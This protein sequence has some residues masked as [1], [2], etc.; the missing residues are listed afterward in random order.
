MLKASKR[1]NAVCKKR[2]KAE[3]LFTPGQPAYTAA[4][5]LNNT[6]GDNSF[7]KS[8]QLTAGAGDL[9]GIDGWADIDDLGAVASDNEAIAG[10][11]VG[12]FGDGDVVVGVSEE[13]SVQD[14]SLRFPSGSSLTIQK[15]SPP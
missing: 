3:R 5:Q 15:S 10:E 4:H 14:G 1:L 11:T 6:I 7:Y 8:V 13:T 2:L 12:L 9:N